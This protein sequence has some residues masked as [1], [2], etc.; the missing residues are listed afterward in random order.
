MKKD[1]HRSASALFK[2]NYNH[3]KILNTENNNSDLLEISTK[4]RGIDILLGK[5]NNDSEATSS[6]EN[7]GYVGGMLELNRSDFDFRK[8]P[9]L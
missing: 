5:F 6:V 2:I 3:S 4:E 9:K 7:Q 1:I 8:R